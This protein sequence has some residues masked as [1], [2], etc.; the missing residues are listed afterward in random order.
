MTHEISPL[1]AHQT[2]EQSLV[3]PAM[4]GAPALDTFAGPVRVEWDGETAL[5][6]LGQMPFFIEFLKTAGVFDA[7]VRD[8][9]LTR[10]SPTAA[11]ARDVLGTI[12]LSVLA[13]HR[14]YAHITALRSDGVLPELLG[15]TKVVS[16]DTVR[17]G[18]ANIAGNNGSAWLNRH[19]ERCIYPLLGEPYILDI[20]TTVKPLYGHQE[21]AIV[22]YDP[23]KPGRPSHVHHT[24]MLAGVRLVMGVE[25]MA[26]WQ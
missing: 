24:Y 14:R 9:P 10:K 1:P 17:R 12:M 11:D 16:E 22:G 2:G 26:G 23:K 4:A 20:D 5:T 3:E 13:G 8:C 15:M 25:T 18:L 21:G 7:W 19:I 6:S